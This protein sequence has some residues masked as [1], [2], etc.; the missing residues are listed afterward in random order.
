MELLSI[1]HASSRWYFN[2]C[3]VS[4]KLSIEEKNLAVNRYFVM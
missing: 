4:S 3:N 2:L 1:G